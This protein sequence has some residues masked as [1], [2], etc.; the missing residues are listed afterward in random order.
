M[1]CGGRELLRVAD[2]DPSIQSTRK[3]VIRCNKTACA[4]AVCYCTPRRSKRDTRTLRQH[5]SPPSA[6]TPF[7]LPRGAELILNAVVRFQ[8]K[9]K[10]KVSFAHVRRLF[11]PRK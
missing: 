5:G 8:N 3:D 11:S 1:L 10:P 9:K 6:I 2:S 7:P 4:H